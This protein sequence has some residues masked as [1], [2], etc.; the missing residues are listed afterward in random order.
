VRKTTTPEFPANVPAQSGSVLLLQ[1]Q[2]VASP[3]L[4]RAA[5]RLPTACAQLDALLAE[6]FP[7]A[8]SK[9]SDE[10]KLH[11]RERNTGGCSAETNRA[12]DAVQVGPSVLPI[13]IRNEIA[14]EIPL[15]ES[16]LFPLDTPRQ[17]D[18]WF[19]GLGRKHHYRVNGI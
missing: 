18:I 12:A 2:T 13:R 14:D 11:A 6:A 19:V 16:R 10:C 17:S 4:L 7:C 3:K 5:D 1:H 15:G 9:G 8:P